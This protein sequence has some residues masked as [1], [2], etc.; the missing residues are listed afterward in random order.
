MKKILLSVFALGTL[1]ATAQT[2]VSTNP[3]DRNIVLEE[4]TGIHCGYCPDGHLRAQQ[5]YDNNPGDV[6]LIN[7]HVGGYA[8]PS[9][10]EPDFRTSFGTAIDGQAGVAGYPAGTINRHEF[11]VFNSSAPAGQQWTLS[12]QGGTAMS[13]GDW[14]TTGSTILTQASPVNIG[15]QSSLDIATKVL[16]VDVELYYTGSQTVTSNMLNVAVMQNNVEGPQSGSSANPGSVL[17]N[18]NYNHNHMLRHLMTG[19]WG[20]Q[21]DT[22][23]TGTLISR[24]YTWIL[25]NDINGVDLDP[26]NI[27][28]AVFVSEGNQE[29]ITGESAS[30]TIVFQNS[31]DAFYSNAAATDLNCSTASTDLEISF[32]NYG[33]IPLTSLDIEYAINGGTSITYPWTGNI[34]SGVLETITIPSVAG[35]SSPNNT[36]D[37]TLNNPNGQT[38]QNT[39]DNA[40]NTTFGGLSN[41]TNGDAT[42]III[43]DAYG[44]ETTWDLKDASGI[45]ITSGGPYLDLTAAGTTTQPT[46][47][48]TLDPNTC[49][50]FNIHDTYG[51]GI[52][53]SPGNGSYT[54]TDISGVILAT[55][56]V[57]TSEESAS[58]QTG[59]TTA[60]TDL[61]SD[62]ALYPNPVKDVLTIEGNFTSVNI[63]D[64]FGKLVLSTDA[65]NTIDVSSLSNGVYFVNIKAENTITVKKI[66]VAK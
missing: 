42:I 32:K 5:L 28:V 47:T 44:S 36:V 15:F 38:D 1:A 65:Q 51:D 19:Q 40:G 61:T 41:A 25:P 54:V 53:G 57:F 20:E 2:L 62:L 7:I 56:G 13:R 49:Y 43:T 27:D 11:G 30:S 48:A 55:G 8:A 52:S 50:S 45:T 6:V 4:F 22:I 58:F 18:G 64:I 26:T 37:I 12:Q 21:I 10:G 46:V 14:A 66:T 59:G 9:A 39:G 29:I 33:N 23:T 34:A 35:G 31:Y 24:T 3:E 63:L 16:T 17:A 60:V